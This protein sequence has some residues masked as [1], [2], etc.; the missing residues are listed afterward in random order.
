MTSLLYMYETD[1]AVWHYAVADAQKESKISLDATAQWYLGITLMTNIRVQKK[2][3]GT[4]TSFLEITPQADFHQALLETKHLTK[5]SELRRVA[6][7]CLLTCGLFPK[8]FERIGI[9]S[10]W[11]E[12]TG[13]TSYFTLAET[14]NDERSRLVGESFAGLVGVLHFLR[15]TKKSHLRLVVG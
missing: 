5:C 6:D 11:L 14:D 12:Q 4:R 2:H 3:G 15:K 10:N 8:R 13:K 9:K 7:G 1:E